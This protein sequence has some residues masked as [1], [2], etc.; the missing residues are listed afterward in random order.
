MTAM[1]KT[2]TTIVYTDCM[3]LTSFRCTQ[4]GRREP[5]AAG[6][7]WRALAVTAGWMLAVAAIGLSWWFVLVADLSGVV[8]RLGT[9]AWTLGPIG[10][11]IVVLAVAGILA[12][13][14]P[15]VRALED[16]GRRLPWRGGETRPDEVPSD[17]A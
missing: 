16:L 7:P 11:G 10:V 4:V 1:T 3:S 17:K 15:P 6:R 13:R 8:Y 5:R 12:G 2:K 9:P 14:L